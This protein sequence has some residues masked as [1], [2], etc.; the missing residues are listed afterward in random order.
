MDFCGYFSL[1]KR[2][3]KLSLFQ[4]LR[5]K[6]DGGFFKISRSSKEFMF[7]FERLI[8]A[9]EFGFILHLVTGYHID[10]W[11]FST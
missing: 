1:T 4:F 9:F 5:G 10:Q 7:F 3:L 2:G 6:E 8:I 11:R